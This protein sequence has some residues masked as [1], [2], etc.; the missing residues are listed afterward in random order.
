MPL[1]PSTRLVSVDDHLIEPPDLWTSRVPKRYGD[2]IPHVEKLDGVDT[3]VYA[4]ELYPTSMLNAV[5]GKSADEFTTDAISYDQMRPGVYQP[6]AR[7]ADMDMADVY[8]SLCFPTFSRGAGHR[9]L[10]GS[11]RALAL[12]CV[13]AYNDYM[14]EEWCGGA[15]DRLYPMIYLPLWDVELAETELFRTAGLGAK[16]ITF[17]ENPSR[18]GLPSIHTGYWDP[19]Y[20]AAEETGLPLCMHIGSSGEVLDSSE[21]SPYAVHVSLMG[22]G[23]MIALADYCFS[24]VL[25]TFPNLKLVL[26]EG[27][28]GWIPYMLERMDHSWERHKSHSG[29]DL[30][31]LPSELFSRNFWVCLFAD[32][33]G[34]AARHQIGVDRILWE[35]DYPHADSLW[36]DCRA[37]L[38][39][40]LRDVPDDEAYAI[41]EG[42][43][44]RLFHV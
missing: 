33:V 36:P 37:A 41:A 31:S 18:L 25:E 1:A 27:G 11:D 34:V 21:D 24:H 19:V 26:S 35:C 12:D 30:K 6:A 3:W 29:I 8:G 10:E 14:I 7:L 16:A 22:C 42:N 40:D 13:R 32:S 2:K 39:K 17:S 38:E 4:G 15:P 9:F 44:R 5:A 20:R 43:A 28:A 23:S